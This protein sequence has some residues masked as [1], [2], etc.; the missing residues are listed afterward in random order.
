MNRRKTRNRRRAENS[1]THKHPYL[2]GA[3]SVLAG[4]CLAML[5]ILNSFF[6]TLN[7][8]SFYKS[9]ILS[10]DVHVEGREENATMM[11]VDY[12]NNRIG[13]DAFGDF[14]NEKERV[15]LEDVR[16]LIQGA[17]MISYGLIALFILCMAYLAFMSNGFKEQA[18]RTF[19]IAGFAS[20]GMLLIGAIA[21]TNFDWA[22]IKF[23]E[24]LFTNDFWLLDPA[25]DHLIQL[26]PQ[27]F[28]EAFALRLGMLSA[29]SSC[30]LIASGYALP[31]IK[32]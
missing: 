5:I 11:L 3:A 12:L 22:F 4:I 28:F 27:D 1:I 2:V 21:L 14:F 31:R 16:G 10:N 13:I 26:F 24:V 19:W 29:F 7:D 25:T 15:H 9:Q 18:A 30:V 23:H 8:R 17:R 32:L 20:L 6:Y